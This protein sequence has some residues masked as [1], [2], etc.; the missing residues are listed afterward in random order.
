MKRDWCTIL[1]AVAGIALMVLWVI[2]CWWW[3]IRIF[4]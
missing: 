1:V 4:I 2:A 3:L